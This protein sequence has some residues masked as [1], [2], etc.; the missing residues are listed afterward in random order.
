MLLE[1]RTS[2]ISKPKHLVYIE[3]EITVGGRRGSRDGFNL[4]T[5]GIDSA[6]KLEECTCDG[7]ESSGVVEWEVFL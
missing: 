1:E 5:L 7:P 3:V 4:F 2:R 6:H